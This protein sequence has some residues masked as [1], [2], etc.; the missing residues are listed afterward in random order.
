MNNPVRSMFHALSIANAG[1]QIGDAYATVRDCM[2]MGALEL[3]DM[4]RVIVGQRSL[5]EALRDAADVADDADDGFDGNSLATAMR[6][7]ATSIDA[8]GSACPTIR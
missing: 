5:S 7:A 1:H 4:L 2:D 8:I 6:S 3:E